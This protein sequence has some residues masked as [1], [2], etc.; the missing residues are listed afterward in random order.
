[1][2]M[3]IPKAALPHCCVLSSVISKDM[4]GKEQCA[5]IEL[6]HVKIEPCRRRDYSLQGELSAPRATLFF[7]AVNSLPQG[8]EFVAGDKITFFGTEYTIT[9]AAPYYADTSKLHHW[10]VLLS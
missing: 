1:M 8:I 2:V 3:P 6:S 7:D 5:S 4:W 10:E 9:E